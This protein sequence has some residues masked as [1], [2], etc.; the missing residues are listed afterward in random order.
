MGGTK[1]L[2]SI[3][4]YDFVLCNSSLECVLHSTISPSHTNSTNKITIMRSL[5]VQDNTGIKG[6]ITL[7]HLLSSTILS[8]Q[9]LHNNECFN[10]PFSGTRDST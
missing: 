6:F 4:F 1:R 10:Q 8:I 7:S 9:S 3:I 2:K 5:F